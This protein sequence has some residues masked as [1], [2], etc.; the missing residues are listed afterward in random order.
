MW[1][2][3]HSK[4]IQYLFFFTH[5]DDYFLLVF[6]IFVLTKEQYSASKSLFMFGFGLA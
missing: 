6:N 3:K 5:L 4:L 2:K 1:A